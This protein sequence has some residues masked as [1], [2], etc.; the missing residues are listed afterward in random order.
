[1]QNIYHEGKINVLR[2]FCHIVNLVL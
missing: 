1:V 2:Y